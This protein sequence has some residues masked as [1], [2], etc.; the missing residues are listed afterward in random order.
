MMIGQ[1]GNEPLNPRNCTLI[2]A[3]WFCGFDGFSW[4]SFDLFVFGAN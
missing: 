2:S 4:R 3:G 1:Q